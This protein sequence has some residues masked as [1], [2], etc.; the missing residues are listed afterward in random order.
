MMARGYCYRRECQ[1]GIM[2]QTPMSPI[3]SFASHFTTMLSL[4]LSGTRAGRELS[5][6]STSGAERF[7]VISYSSP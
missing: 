2:F 7:V 3:P 4:S 1:A 6:H 5:V